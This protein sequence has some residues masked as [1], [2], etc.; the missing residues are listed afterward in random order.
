MKPS[1]MARVCAP[2]L[3][4]VI[5]CACARG[6]S[7]AQAQRVIESN[8]LV[9]PSADHVVVDAI[10]LSSDTE[11]IVRATIADQ[12]INLK[13]RRYDTGWTWEFMETKGGGWI[14]PDQGVGQIRESNRQLRIVQ[15]FAKNEEAYR[16][17]IEVIDAYTGL[18]GTTFVDPRTE[19][20]WR[21]VRK[22]T[23]KNPTETDAWGSEVL[24][25][26]VDDERAV[27]F[28]KK[29][30]FLSSGPDKQK[31]TD[32]DVVCV[33]TGRRTVEYDERIWTYDLSWV[34]PEGLRSIVSSHVTKTF[35]SVEYS[36]LIKQ[37]T[38][39]TPTTEPAT[40]GMRSPV[41][42]LLCLL[43]QTFAQCE[44]A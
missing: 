31:G 33:A 9:N 20:N 19:E 7:H 13:F 1:A 6:L 28:L 22:L 25:R 17:T 5:S 16:K 18:L 4:I 44:R 43:A 23:H 8:P 37:M 27:L 38:G 12:T 39:A 32:D 40:G 11:A 10:S 41:F 2:L 29:V 42:A 14:A 21:S 15:W 34:V 3:A 24:V 35:A 30:V 36:K 26:F